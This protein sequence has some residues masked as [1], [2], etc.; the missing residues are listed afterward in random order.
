[1]KKLLSS[2]LALALGLSLAVLPASALELDQARELLAVHYVDGV[3]PEVLELPSLD[4]I[5]KAIDD[6]YTF[7]MTPEQYDAFNQSVN[8]QTVVGIGATVETAYNGGYRVMSVLPN[9]PAQ[10]AGIRPGDIITAANG[11]AMSPEV[12]PRIPVSGQE[13]TSV[14]LTINRNGQTLELTL[15]RRAVPIPIVTYEQR[16]GAGVI[17]CISFGSTTASS[18]QEAILSMDGDTSVWIMDLRSNPGGDSRSTAASVSLFTGGGIMLYFR[19][20]AGHYNYTYTLPDFPDMTDKPVIV[21]TSEHSASGSELF[22][23]GIRTYDA[24]IALGQRTF[25]KG[26]AQIVFEERNCPYMKNGEAM[27]ITAYR[28]FAPDGATNH[29]TGVLP[30]LLISPENTDKAAMLLTHPEPRRLDGYWKLV[31]SGQTFYLKSS[32]AREEENQAAFTELLEALPLSAALYKGSGAATWTLVSPEQAASELGLSF[33]PRTF[34][35]TEDSQFTREIDIL[36]TYHILKGFGDGTFR[37]GETI[38]RAQFCAMAASALGLPASA[39]K[40]GRF[41]DVPDSAWYAGAVNAM[42]NMGFVSGSGGT[43]RPGQA[44][45]Y[46][47]MTSI[48]SRVAAWVSMDGYNLDGL[49]LTPEEVEKYSDFAPWAQAPARNLDELNALAGDLAPTDPGTREIAAAMLCRLM[50]RTHLIWN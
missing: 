11:T 19:D 42:A 39:G 25:G 28:F 12:D 8:G 45:T 35:D 21:L 46:Q 32:D 20:G 22:A 29:V 16:D 36:A 9:S 33:T 23:G 38:S 17:D 40:P 31:L 13:G 43:F 47:E 41:S 14:T 7:Y 24:G 50:E 6:P 30:T 34:T 26:T 1:M 27:K 44:I 10:E 4:A 49:L 2:L 48:L 3:P 15:T 5:L 18:V 37:P